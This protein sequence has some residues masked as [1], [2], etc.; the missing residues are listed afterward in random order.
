M[1]EQ[2]VVIDGHL[3]VERQP[4]T[5]PGQDEG[6]DF[7]QGGVFFQVCVVQLPR[8]GRKPGHPVG[9]ESE[10]ESDLSRLPGTETK[11]RVD[12]GAND[13]LWPVARDLLD[14]DAALRAGHDHVLPAGAI[15]G[16]PEV[17]L[18]SDIDGGSDQHLAHDVPA[19]VETK[20]RR[21]GLARLSWRAGEFDASR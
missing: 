7:R 5:L 6:V 14:I 10:R 16:Y 13:P 21:G 11:K 20:D 9:R 3:G 2:R 12:Q 17:D 18:L 19:N 4:I 1:T 15:E 8:D